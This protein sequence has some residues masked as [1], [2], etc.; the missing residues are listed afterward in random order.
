L[1][2][3]EDMFR[4]M[5]VK[6]AELIGYFVGHGC[7]HKGKLMLA[8]PHDSLELKD[9]FDIYIR[10]AFAIVN[11]SE[12]ESKNRSINLIYHSQMLVKWL[13]SIG[14]DKEDSLR[15]F[16]PFIIFYSFALF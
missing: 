11:R 8:I 13:K 15:A 12:Q 5:D 7:F 10:S 4:R 14:V 2:E 1:E 9:Y 3:P 16:I 6:L